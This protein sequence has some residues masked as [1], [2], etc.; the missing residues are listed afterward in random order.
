M[1]KPT[2]GMINAISELRK[3]MKVTQR[4]S[5]MKPDEFKHIR[6]EVIKTTQSALAGILKNPDNGESIAPSVLSRWEKGLLPVPLWAAQR[7]RMLGEHARR[8]DL[9]NFE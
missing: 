9:E 8:L 7:I 5:H 6:V 3:K 1:G 4:K 2:E